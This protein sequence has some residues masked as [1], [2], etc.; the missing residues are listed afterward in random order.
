MP[1]ISLTA[2]CAFLDDYLTPDQ[3]KDYCP[4]GLQVEGKN[5]VRRILSGVT[6]CQALLDEAVA[7]GFDCVLVHHGYF[8][9]GEDARIIG[10]RRRRLASLLKN[11]ISLIAYHLPLDAHP[12]VGNN[13]QLGKR[14]GWQHSGHFGEQDLGWLG[15][16]AEPLSARALAAQLSAGLGREALCVGADAD[17]EAP[18]RTIGWCSGGAQSY[19]E[20]AIAAGA[21]AFVSGEISEPCTHLARESGVPYLACGHH[22]T[23]RDGVRALGEYIAREQGLEVVFRDIDNP[24]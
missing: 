23:E 17:L 3:F 2:L 15:T 20:A 6:A 12:V 24:V 9:R 4:N 19:F 5:T 11:D 16:L 14:F 7:G 22:A 8:W 18:L 21:E 10:M 1:R 13:A